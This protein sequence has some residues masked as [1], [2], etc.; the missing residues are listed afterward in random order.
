MK[1]SCCFTFT[2]FL[3][4]LYIYDHNNIQLEVKSFV[5]NTI[6]KYFNEKFY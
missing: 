4:D 5:K 1:K 2:F 3:S 6:M